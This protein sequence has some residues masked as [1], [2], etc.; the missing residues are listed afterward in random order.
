MAFCRIRGLVKGDRGIHGRSAEK[1]SAFDD[2][3]Y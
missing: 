1:W 3:E 2:P